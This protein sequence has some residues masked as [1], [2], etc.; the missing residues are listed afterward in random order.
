MKF[1][2]NLSDKQKKYI[3]RII[4]LT[5]AVILC[6]TAGLLYMP[7][8]KLKATSEQSADSAFSEGEGAAAE[9][10]SSEDEI[11]TESVTEE[12]TIPP[13]DAAEPE[14]ESV[15]SADETEVVGEAEEERTEV[16]F[17]NEAEPETAADDMIFDETETAEEPAEDS[18]TSSYVSDS[19]SFFGDWTESGSGE[20]GEQEFESAAEEQEAGAALNASEDGEADQTESG[21]TGSKL[22]TQ[23][24]ETTEDWEKTLPETLTGSWAD[25]IAAVAESQL[26]YQESTIAT[27]TTEGGTVRRGYTRYGDWNGDAYEDWSL[28]FAAFCL[29]YAEIDPAVVPVNTTDSSAW[30]R[31]LEDAEY[32][33]PVRTDMD[34]AAE[35]VNDGE[36]GFVTDFARGDLVFFRNGKL[37]NAS[38][39]HIGIV[40]ETADNSI[41]VIEGDRNNAVEKNTYEKDSSDITAAFALPVNQYTD[42]S[43]EGADDGSSGLITLNGEDEDL[44]EDGQSD[45]QTDTEE[46]D[47]QDGSE[48]ED[49][50]D[51]WYTTED[52][53]GGEEAE[54]GSQAAE[55]SDEAEPDEKADEQKVGQETEAEDA[56]SDS[57]TAAYASG[58]RHVRVRGGNYTITVSFGTECKIPEDAEF[59]AT[60]ISRIHKQHAFYSEQAIAAVADQTG[61]DAQT[62]A[63]TPELQ[64]E[65]LFDLSIYDKEGNEIQPAAPLQVAVEMK[66]ETLETSQEIHAVHFSGTELQGNQIVA[67]ESGTPFTT[68]GS[69][70][71]DVSG[72][73]AQ[74][75]PEVLGTSSEAGKTVQ[76]QVESFSLYAIVATVIEKNIL[77]SDGHNYKVTVTCSPDAGIPKD[78]ELEVDELLDASADYAY[79]LAKAEDAL[80]RKA[81]SSD[82]ARFFDI[83]IVMDG[84]EIQ[85]A[86]GSTVDVQ[87]ELTDS[88]SGSLQVVHFGEEPEV[89]DVTA[90]AGTVSFAAAGFSVYAIVDAP[91]APTAVSGWNSIKSVEDLARIG[92]QGVYAAHKDGYY[93]TDKITKISNVRTGIT[94]T[95]KASS[96]DEAAGAVLYYFEQLEG[97]A[98]QFYVFCKDINTGAPRYVKQSANSLTLISDKAEATVFTARLFTGTTDNFVLIGSNN[99]CWNMQGGVNGKS[100]AAYD[101]TEDVNARIKL[102]YFNQIERDPYHLDGK[103]YGIAYHNDTAAAAALT[104]KAKTQ[105][106]VERLEAADMLMRPDVLD[107][108]GI[109]LVAANSDITEWTFHCDHEDRYYITTTVNGLKKYLTINGRNIVLTDEAGRGENSL[110][111]VIPGSD[112]NSGKYRF[113]AGGYALEINLSNNSTA[114]GF[115]GSTNNADTNWLNLVEKSVLPEEDFTLYAARKVSVSD[116]ENVYDKEEDG[117]RQQSQI[118]IYTRIWNDMTKKYEF[119]AVDHDGSLVRC[120]DTGDGIEWIA[121]RVNTALWTFTEYRN[122]DGTSTH[123]YELQNVQYGNYIA[124]QVS[125]GQILSNKPLGVNLNG[126]RYGENYTPIIAWDDANYAFAGLKT[127]KRHIVSCPLAEAEDFYFAV[128]NPEKPDETEDHLTEVKTIDSSQYGISMKMIDFNNPLAVDRDSVQHAFFGSHPN[129]YDPGLL[130]TDLNEEG[131]PTTTE[132]TGHKDPL[133]KLF[134]GMTDVNHLFLQSVYN[135][136][137]Y[138]EYDSTSNFA[139]LNEDGTFTVYDQ[140]GAIGNSTGPTRTHGQFMPYNNIEAGKFAYDSAGKPITNQTDVLATELSDLNP[141]KGEKLYSIPQDKADY[142]F[143]MEMAASFTQTASGLDAWGHDIIFE[144]SGDDDFWLYVDNE[145]VLDLGGVRSAM[146]GSVNFRTGDIV[147]G[148]TKTTLYETFKKNYQTRGLSQKEIEKKLAEIFT[149]NDDGQ[150]IFRDYT[151]HTMKMFYMERGQGASNLHMRF[152]LA[153]VRPGTVV[154]SKK[155]S[156]TENAA[157][158]LIEFPYQIYYRL[159]KDGGDAYHLLGAE[160]GDTDRVTY[161][162]TVNTVTYRNSFT[163]AGGSVAYKHVF[164]LKP[165]ESAV[166]DLPDDTLDYYIVE[167]GVN[168]AVYDR[169][170]ANDVVLT[171]KETANAGRQDFATAPAAAADRPEVDYDN[172]VSEG[173]MRTLTITKKLYDVDGKTA[174]VYPQDSTLFTFRLYLGNENADA[175]NLPRANLYSYFVKDPQGNYCRWN[176]AEQ[177]FESLGFKDYSELSGYLAGLSGAEKESVIF[178]TSM[179]GS[180]SKIPADYIIEVR[181]LIVGTQFKVEE[182]DEEIPRGYTLRLNDGYQRLDTVPQ[183]NTQTTPISGTIQ[184]NEDP[185]ILVSNQKGWG[186]TLEKIWTDRDFMETHDP[187]YFAVYVKGTKDGEDTFELLD[188]SVRELKTNESSIYYF[189]GNLQSGIPFANYIVREVNVEAEGASLT[190]DNRGVVSG[191]KTVTP[192]EEGGNLTIGGKPVGGTYSESGYSYTVS[193]YPGEQTT[194]NEN[195]R[196]DRVV[197]SRPGIEIYK[198]DWSGN[199]LAGAVFTLKD[200]DGKNVAAKFYTSAADDGLITTAYLS[201][202]TYTMTETEAPQGYTVMD[203]PMTIK[204]DRDDQGK[205]KITVSGPD[206]AYY[207][208][209][210]TRSSMAARIT[211]KNRPSAFQVKKVDALTGA[212]LKDVHFALYRQVTDNNG[213]K[214]KDYNPMKGYENLTTDENG[215]LEKVSMEL[216]A[217]TYYLTET[218]AAPEYDLLKEDICFTIG[219]DGTVTVDDGI[220]NGWLKSE[221]D[222]GEGKGNISYSI[223][224]PNGKMKKIS[225]KKVD[226]GAPNQSALAGAEF[227]L[228]RVTDGV[229]EETPLMKGLASGD[230]GLLAKGKQ[231]VFE[232]PDGTYELIETK[233][234][235]GYN[236]K[237][238]PVTVTI[239]TTAEEQSIT[240]GEENQEA[241]GATRYGV[242]YDE[243]TTLSVDGKGITRDEDTKV[244]T[245]L[246]SN[247]AGFEL[248][249]TG[250]PGT[251]MFTILGLLLILGAGLM[252]VIRRR[253]DLI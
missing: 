43:E 212:A 198:Q 167:C 41:T 156:G 113:T 42:G 6:V 227:D 127:E 191:Y 143:G 138:F 173:A 100:I 131:Y 33:L 51:N 237:V 251:R 129:N 112:A 81:G 253:N 17:G 136:S 93:L 244:V 106:G 122:N 133:S 201:E 54:D 235:A 28:D 203:Q 221:S 56:G 105:S 99:Y 137:G 209:E 96:P 70:S 139:H 79:Y 36:N 69:E 50:S 48:D 8:R 101:N 210:Y 46:E 49:G 224:I 236:L 204:V 165:G 78:A 211:I 202:G 84:K 243:G 242:H 121:S 187:I 207:E 163:P 104:A 103:T 11:T 30:I 245:V 47:L 86:E 181:D 39:P 5:L 1:L 152:N 160:N 168:P 228:Y 161:K 15:S 239:G 31:L 82:Y 188:G 252:A 189:F 130:S 20:T 63:G 226:I 118:I 169:V 151:N 215:I 144:F 88:D 248:P 170:T 200:A 246:I 107:N 222:S 177:K 85:P 64:V 12:V 216:G 193:Y 89:L 117:E 58:V 174:L 19:S 140:L 114:N 208:I 18:E 97:T 59:R 72:T 250:G 32:V 77:A 9:A 62:D 67:A 158:N 73:P 195:V 98:D 91:E 225:F 110:I 238:T 185:R 24:H 229:R 124:P 109:L 14:T 214:R 95:A 233:A 120:Y 66:Q 26:G 199:A 134:T 111:Q 159:K 183:Q 192:I 157:N 90:E 154:L 116:E 132:K 44:A 179:N 147:N 186:L 75:E 145:L 182:R 230:D 83:R 247:H 241:N 10:G 4:A 74:A 164:F 76:F 205:A 162:G 150:Y 21:E 13:R 80:G 52:T 40:L 3:K 218:K 25:D 35:P 148:S 213:N 135:E 149:K 38:V 53:D 180:V 60:A 34:T 68:P 217:G 29:Y 119:Y 178:K 166:I 196:T 108:E 141:R 231:K 16:G 71:G 115:W 57:D 65:Y 172:H 142:F 219:R 240:D 184:V 197:N 55:G 92:R 220:H 7:D 125:G 37:G 123:Y 146:T 190:V 128:V 232:L 23:D 249:H 94:K 45:A 234:P 126:R 102:E 171:G 153:A 206:K 87:V 27:R 22:I 61:A 223:E 176:T 155:L 194:Q 175:A 2:Q